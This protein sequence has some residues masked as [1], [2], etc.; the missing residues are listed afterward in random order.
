MR[1]ISRSNL[2]WCSLTKKVENM[3]FIKTTLFDLL[4]SYLE[5]KNI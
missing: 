3:L 2:R 4:K 5:K 1:N